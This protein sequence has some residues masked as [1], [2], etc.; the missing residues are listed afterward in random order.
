M[1]RVK[2][3]SDSDEE[4]QAPTTP[5]AV[6]QP[7]KAMASQPQ[8]S[9]VV[10][11]YRAKV[12]LQK[13]QQQALAS[14]AAAAAVCPDPPGSTYHRVHSSYSVSSLSQLFN[15]GGDCVPAPTSRTRRI[16]IWSLALIVLIWTLLCILTICG[17]SVACSSVVGCHSDVHHAGGN[18][19]SCHFDCEA[20][21]KHYKAELQHSI[22]TAATSTVSDDKHISDAYAV[23]ADVGTICNMD[24]Y[25]LVFFMFKVFI[26][27]KKALQYLMLNDPISLII[28]ASVD[29]FPAFF[30]F[31]LLLLFLYI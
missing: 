7:E 6:K 22:C 5:S 19:D 29:L 2:P 24:E 31:F 12:Q 4:Q 20:A 27:L 13:Q 10:E 8:Q 30:S 14:R 25:W 18:L 11:E 15:V 9:S 26:D 16:V 1:K 28:T 17:E 23:V 3:P 21:T